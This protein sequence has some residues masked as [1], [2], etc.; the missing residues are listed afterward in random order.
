MISKEN[1]FIHKGLERF[2]SSGGVDHSKIN[3]AHTKTL[4]M[5]LTHLNAA[6]S[7]QDLQAG[8]GRQKIV[9]TS[10]WA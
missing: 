2:W 4:R 8:Q 1:S 6:R 10:Q 9:E 3:A 7:L 5:N